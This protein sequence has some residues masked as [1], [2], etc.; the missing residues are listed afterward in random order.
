MVMFQHLRWPHV[1]IA[2]VF[3]TVVANSPLCVDGFT[4]NPS[5]PAKLGYGTISSSRAVFADPTTTTAPQ[6]Q[7]KVE[8]SKAVN[9]K[10]EQTPMKKNG[11]AVRGSAK[12]NTPKV[13]GTVAKSKKNN[14]K[15]SKS[16]YGYRYR[17]N[18]KNPSSK[19]A[20]SA[21]D[22]EQAIEMVVDSTSVETKQPTKTEKKSNKIKGQ[23]RN[24][25]KTTKAKN[26][27]RSKRPGKLLPLKDIVI[28][29][30][31]SGKIVDLCSFGAFVQT[32]YAIP[33]T[34]M[35]CALL[36][37]SQIRDEKVNDIN[38]VLKKGQYIENARFLSVDE[39]KG[40]VRISLRK[41][42]TRRKSIKQMKVGETVEGK[43]L[44]LTDYGAFV[45]VGCKNSALLHKSQ[46]SEKKVVDVADILKVG[47]KVQVEITDVDMNKKTMACTM[48]T[49]NRK[50]GVNMAAI[51]DR[52]NKGGSVDNEVG[53]LDDD[54]ID[55]LKTQLKVCDMIQELESTLESGV[56]V[57]TWQR[58]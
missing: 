20:I 27:K 16:R 15:G 56:E 6:K 47:Q 18:K 31:V 32:K 55:T 30:E 9:G 14:R 22:A 41:K 23:K 12:K 10:T 24:G 19:N 26:G 58:K 57:G 13:N 42:K 7:K 39:E 44:S 4:V 25:S 43:I 5:V 37:I 52:V 28:G 2:C 46:M 17:R 21:E 38:D 1:A 33:G 3:A 54:S 11:G 51:I 50:N 36:H 29:S 53:L 40:E 49:T 35:G 34:R 48:R 45:D 8:R